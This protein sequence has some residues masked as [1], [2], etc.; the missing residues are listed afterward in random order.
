MLEFGVSFLNFQELEEETLAALSLTIK[1]R[2]EEVD[3]SSGSEEETTQ[4]Q[5]SVLDRIGNQPVVEG[6]EG[7]TEF[8]QMQERALENLLSHSVLEMGADTSV[9]GSTGRQGQHDE[10]AKG[11]KRKRRGRESSSA[12]RKKR[13]KTPATVPSRSQF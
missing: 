12:G 4:Q 7:S 1:N 9:T 13:P 5:S 8:S 2:W 3:D 10:T 6:R 11:S